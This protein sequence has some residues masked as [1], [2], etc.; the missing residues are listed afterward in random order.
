MAIRHLD[1]QRRIN[2]ASHLATHVRDT[3]FLLDVK[4]FK[5]GVP[6]EKL[7]MFFEVLKE[8]M[9]DVENGKA[10][11]ENKATETAKRA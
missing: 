5:C 6:P 8:K 3:T 1:V 11:A 7:G 2:I 10:K 9:R 4:G